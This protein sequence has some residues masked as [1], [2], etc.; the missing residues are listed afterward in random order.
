MAYENFFLSF[1]PVLKMRT[2]WCRGSICAFYDS[3]IKEPHSE[4]TEIPGVIERKIMHSENRLNSLCIQFSLCI[5]MLSMEIFPY[6]PFG[7]ELKW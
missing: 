1:K 5:S 2:G 3:L 7:L 4:K 6:S